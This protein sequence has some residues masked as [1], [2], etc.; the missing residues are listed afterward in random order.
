MSKNY[1][2]NKLYCSNCNKVINLEDLYK[3]GTL[4]SRYVQINLV[5]PYCN[6]ILNIDKL[7]TK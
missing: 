1:K 5:C 2:K 4:N 6:K 3:I 7:K